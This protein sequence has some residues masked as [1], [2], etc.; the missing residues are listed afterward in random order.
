MQY[1]YNTLPDD[2]RSFFHQELN[3]IANK[4]K[5][6]KDEWNEQGHEAIKSCNFTGWNFVDESTFCVEDI[7]TATAVLT[8]KMLAR[9][10]YFSDLGQKVTEVLMTV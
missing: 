9:N 3:A 8:R 7:A 2:G 10:Q 6:L 5:S 1:S 4:L